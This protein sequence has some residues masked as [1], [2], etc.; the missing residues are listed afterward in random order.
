VYNIVIEM[1]FDTIKDSDVL[2]SVLNSANCDIHFAKTWHVVD[3]L[4]VLSVADPG[5]MS[6]LHSAGHL[7]SKSFFGGI[8]RPRV[9]PQAMMLILSPC[10]AAVKCSCLMPLAE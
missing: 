7:P 10:F 3:H 4:M 6:W 1:R 5:G 8:A 2:P 9:P